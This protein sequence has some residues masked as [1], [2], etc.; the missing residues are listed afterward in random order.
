M[1]RALNNPKPI[2]ERHIRHE[3]IS[4]MLLVYHQK[5]MNRSDVL[6]EP[7]RFFAVISHHKALNDQLFCNDREKPFLLKQE[8][9]VAF[10]EYA[11]ETTRNYFLG[12]EIYFVGLDRAYKAFAVDRLEG[13]YHH[14]FG[15]DSSSGLVQKNW[16]LQNFQTRNEYI[17][18]K[19]LLNIADWTASGHRQLEKPLEYSSDDLENK[20]A[21]RARKQ[22]REYTGLREFQKK[23]IVPGHV[24]AI[25]P[26]GSGKTEA[27]LLWSSQREGWEKILFLLP[28]RV[29]SNA[30]YRRLHEYFG[31]AD[32][33]DDYTAVVHSSAKL[34]RQELDETYS[35]LSYYRESAF[36]KAVTV[37][38]VDQLLTQGF[39]LGWWEMKTFHLFKA[40]VIID[41][42]HAY[43]PYTLG[44]IV[45][46]IEYLRKEFQTEFYI[47]TATMP[48]QLQEILTEA[49]GGAE[50]RLLLPDKELLSKA[51]NHYR[52]EEKTINQLKP[53]IE[54]RLKAGKKVL[55]VVNTVN[56]AI[57]LYDAYN[58]FY[59]MVYHSRF[60]TRHRTEKEQLILEKEDHEEDREGFL[61]IATQV[62][63]VS[64]DIDYDYLY[65]ENAPIDAIIQRAGRVNR[66]RNE[67]K[68]T[69][70]VIF[71]H[72]EV[73]KKVYEE[74]E[75]KTKQVYPV[76]D[77]TFEILSQHNGEKLTESQLLEM[78]DNVYKDWKIK[79]DADYRDAKVKYLIMQDR[80]LSY[81]KDNNNEDEKAF[82]RDGLDTVSIIPM[83][84]EGKLK[85]APYKEKKK[86]E[87]TIQ[88]SLFN[89]LKSKLRK[90]DLATDDHGFQY[91]EV[92][93]DFEKGLYFDSQRAKELEQ[94]P[95]TVNL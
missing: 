82:T 72:L 58:N 31:K 24:L 81:I 50:N 85:K 38:T 11:R 88:R 15:E 91:I 46:T 69:E 52:V 41:E 28:T 57:R 53:E 35:D 21:E 54:E 10:L 2:K 45:A 62:V 30:L 25:A 44:L 40:K 19:S 33:V 64:L 1:T 17:I 5:L 42:I 14:L 94:D 73:S 22:K 8:D 7:V 76:L 77:K 68:F 48:E 20:L 3:F 27:S 92:P 66:K 23:S 6:L 18:R 55:L 4:G 84:F 36:F 47:M 67:E 34:F 83:Q 65:T 70:V 71:P 89:I 13:M 29:T 43:Q 80:N 39:N 75:N 79:D 12:K 61:L 26:T 56:E 87:V 37:A 32:E 63:E 95:F 93:Y 90:T 60:I 59:R 74:S 16:K 86:Y 49:L 78:V 9:F 51:R